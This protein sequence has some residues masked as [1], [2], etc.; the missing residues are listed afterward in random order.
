MGRSATLIGGALVI[1]ACGSS[2]PPRDGPDPAGGAGGSSAAAGASSG[3]ASTGGKNNGAGKGGGGTSGR[4][5]GSGGKAPPEAGEGGEAGT[6][7]E[8]GGDAGAE[9]GGNA[10][11]GAEAGNGGVGG[12]GAAAGSSGTAG[13]GATAG[14]AGTGALVLSVDTGAAVHAISP[15]IY[16]INP[17]TLRCSD[18][19]ARFGLCRL[20]GNPWST[21]NWEN[22]ASNPGHDGCFQNDGA[23]GESDT[24]G[25]G[26]TATLDEAVSAGAAALVTL[27]V[28]DYV[29]A[30][31]LGA[32]GSSGCGDVRDSGA[33]YL[34]TRFKLNRARKG[35]TLAN[36]PDTSDAYVNQDEFVAFL[37]DRS[38]GGEL[39]F[40]VG[41]EPSLWL[42]THAPL[43]PE[44][45][46]YAEV[47][48]RNVEYATL[49][50]DLWPAAKVLGYA[51]YGWLDFVSLQGAPDATGNGEFVDYYLQALKSAS[52]GYGTPLI[53]YLD[54]HWYPELYAEGGERIIGNATGPEAVALRVQATRSLWDPGYVEPSWIATASG[55]IALIPR[56]KTKLDQHFP[57]TKLAISEWSYGGGN[58]VSGALATADALGIFGREQVG[59]AAFMSQS[60]DDAFVQGAF[61]VFR[62]YDG[63]GAAFGDRS[64]AAASSDPARASIYASV[65]SDDANRIVIVAINRSDTAEDATLAITHASPLASAQVFVLSAAG[66]EPAAAPALSASSPGTFAYTLPAYSISVI[67]PGAAE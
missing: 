36:P 51:G 60:D 40:N 21:Y 10:G 11:S 9:E 54:V 48:A 65:A 47:V 57:G 13:S 20:G 37:R 43:H 5:A 22:N 18:A 33:D 38:S 7:T 6:G 30:D 16:G 34:T 55:A 27:P 58:H 2:D 61:R 23:L 41:N 19:G 12:G 44:Q 52:D 14:S 46:T 4:S 31:K 8:Q 50:R 67:V 53:D 28:L 45:P 17:G 26:V 64:V 29:A 66:P 63:Q 35:S 25:A 39:L 49:V 59:L 3:G 15:L 62:N 32:E 56:L 1:V 42:E 24:P